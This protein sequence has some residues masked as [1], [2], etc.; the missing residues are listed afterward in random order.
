M[1][2]RVTKIFS[3]GKFQTT[4]HSC[5]FMLF[6]LVWTGL[7]FLYMKSMVWP[8]LCLFNLHK[9]WKGGMVL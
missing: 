1:L 2:A 9:V 4:L 8:T 5:N 6:G 3:F 7:V